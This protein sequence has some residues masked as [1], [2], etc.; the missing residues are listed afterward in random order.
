MDDKEILGSDYNTALASIQGQ[1]Q[2][3]GQ[4]PTSKEAAKQ[5]KNQQL[6]A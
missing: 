3:M 4:D 2:Q 6:T 5:V 1:L